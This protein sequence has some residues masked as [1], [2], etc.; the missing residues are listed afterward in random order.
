MNNEK[1]YYHFLQEVA[2]CVEKKYAGKVKGEIVT[3]IKNN[4]V[5]V[6]GLMLKDE[7]KKVA[8]NFYLEQYFTDWMS[9]R[10]TLDEIAEKLCT[11]YKE[12]MKQSA[13][14]ASDIQFSWEV[15]R[16]KVFMRLI[17]REKNKELLQQVPYRE[18]MDLAIV[19]YYSL[20]ISDAVVGTML[21]T[22]EHLH[23]LN[24]SAEELHQAAQ[25]NCQRFQ[26]VKLQDM[27]E[28][29]LVIGNKTGIPVPEME[30]EELQPMYVLSNTIG[31]YGAVAMV[32]EEELRRFSER[33]KCS[34]YVLPSSIHEVILIPECKECCVEY[35]LQMV[36]E[37]NATQ[38]ATTEVL[39]DSVY[40]YDKSLEKLRRV[41]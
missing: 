4:N 22:E 26:P 24:V 40:F 35:F 17:N 6:T 32:F 37:I 12:E 29:M 39:S 30:K 7:E 41:G 23:L 25:G 16:R 27:K 19:Y 2:E 18:F 15:F 31:M 34:F 13:H 21:I 28:I 5:S 11:V 20:Q 8:P 38:V 36:K 9:G 1:E 10:M 33:L 3:S 14:L